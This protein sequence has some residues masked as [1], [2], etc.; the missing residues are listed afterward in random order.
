MSDLPDD[1][2]P[3]P[4]RLPPQPT[5]PLA[6]PIYL[7]SV[8]RCGDPKQ[9][10]AMLAGETPGHVYSRDGHPNAV[11]LAEKC[12]Q[13]HRAERAA[14]TASGMGA[15][16]L[17]AL[18][19][20][21]SGDHLVASTMLYGRSQLLAVDELARLG[22]SCTLVDT[23][24]LA[25]TEAALTAQTRLLLVETITNPLLR[26]SDITAL[27]ELAHRRD[28]RLLVDNTLAGPIVCRPLELGADL[29]VESVTKTMNG[30]SDVLLGLLCGRA[31]IWQRV[32][33]VLS[34]WGLAASPF[35]CWLAAR[36]L[37]TLALRI[38]R[39][40]ANALAV[41]RHLAAGL[42]P[43]AAV[44]YPGLAEHPDHA[45][46]RRQF[47]AGFGTLVSFTLRGGWARPSGFW[48]ERTRS[49]SALRSAKPAPR[50][51]IRPVPAIGPR[52]RRPGRRS[53]SRTAR[54][55]CRSASNGPSRSR[56]GSTRVWRRPA[57]Y[58]PAVPVAAQRD[59][60]AP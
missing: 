49:R 29:V 11:L 35:E 51:A 54:S 3:R 47:T 21:K 32:P 12:R 40:G 7:S 20:L 38:D 50:P 33:G 46:S 42:A 59:T 44:H 53:A 26:V 10:A 8:Y 36:G 5:E 58:D 22:I 57:E 43:I 9:T 30:H 31:D 55:D 48:P 41:A 15:L 16:A 28:A 34:T 6:T 45:L 52:A 23:C 13:L 14:I 60:L 19:Q 25:A 17:A 1:I 27:A 18:S 2:C 37:E 4:D 24:N 56:P 39:A